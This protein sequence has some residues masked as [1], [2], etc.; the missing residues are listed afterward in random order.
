MAGNENVIESLALEINVNVNGQDRLTAIQSTLISFA[1]T[2]ETV[3]ARLS[4]FARLGNTMPTINVPQIQTVQQTVEPFEMPDIPFIQL[5]DDN[6]L[7]TIAPTAQRAENAVDSLNET[8]ASTRTEMSATQ[9]STEGLASSFRALGVSILSVTKKAYGFDK[10]AKDNR[11][12]L[13]KLGNAAKQA[14][15]GFSKL[16][17]QFTRIA[18]LRAMRAI[19]RGIVQGVTE[20]VQNLAR[21]DSAFNSTMSSLV[22]STAYLKNAF[23]TLAQPLLE[24]LVPAIVTVIDYI[25]AAINKV[26][27]WIAILHG[28]DTFTAARKYA[29]DYAKSLDKASKSAKEIKRTLLGFDEINRLNDNNSGASGAGGGVDAS[30]M[31]ETRKVDNSDDAVKRV[32]TILRS[33]ERVAGSLLLGIGCILLVTGHLGIG[34]ACIIAGIKLI[35][36][37]LKYG[38]AED[39]VKK[40]LVTI[41]TIVGAASLAIGA[42]LAFTGHLGLGI[43]LIAIGAV[44]LAGSIA[45]DWSSI[46]DKVAKVCSVIGAIVSAALLVIGIIL[47]AAA[48]THLALGIALL[49]AGAVGLATSA[50]LNWNTMSDKTK[51]VISTVAAAAGAALLVI[52]I[53]LAFS[54]VAL[55]LGIALMAAGGVSL[56][57]AAALNWDAM[58]TKFTEAFEKLKSKVT[59]KLAELK[60]KF[61]N[62]R[63]HLKA[64]HLTWQSNGIQTQGIIKKAL[65]ALNLP[66]TLPKLHVDWYAKGGFPEDG[67]FMANHGELVGQFANG[68]TAVANNEQIEA[69]IEEA[70]YRGFMRAMGNNGGGTT[71]FIAQ[72]NGKTLFEEVIR[73]NNSATKAYGSSPLAA[74]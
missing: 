47:V 33:I 45:L 62:W 17:S 53:I 21:F 30:K 22:M 31:F 70:A 51:A 55:P 5:P 15:H 20:G 1:E 66:T 23:G 36:A 54:G 26:N 68:R 11:T 6:G 16:I 40:V 37:S 9:S 10:G 48:P 29:I 7:E 58:T 32:Q 41:E 49:A 12:S 43:A 50:V 61:Q 69:G 8:I 3:N 19:I 64:P 35:A 60:E 59:T 2:L 42:V 28:Q 46:S 4:E 18:R 65:E 56:G 57:T 38:E 34:I 71:T 52:G 27:E 13:Q 39:K 24:L 25:V 14:T 63:A 44:A 74:F 73:Q 72:L 67:L